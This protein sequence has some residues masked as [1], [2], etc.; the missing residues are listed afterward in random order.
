MKKIKFILF[1]FTALLVVVLVGLKISAATGDYTTYV[2]D[3]DFSKGNGTQLTVN[4]YV[5]GDETKTEVPSEAITFTYVNKDIKYTNI[6][7]L[8]GTSQTVNE[9]SKNGVKLNSSGYLKFSAKASWSAELVIGGSATSS[10]GRPNSVHVVS[11]ANQ[12]IEGVTVSGA[13]T[14]TTTGKI[15]N[16]A[17]NFAKDIV[18]ID[19]GIAGEMNIKRSNGEVFIADMI[20]KVNIPNDSETCKVYFYNG[21]VLQDS[22]T[23][24]IIVGNTISAPDTILQYPEGKI[25]AGWTAN[26]ETNELYD[27]TQPVNGELNLYAIW[28]DYSV[29][30]PNVLDSALLDRWG[31]AYHQITKN[32]KVDFIGTNYSI[33]YN[34]NFITDGEITTV[35]KNTGS[36]NVANESNALIFEA[37]ASGKLIVEVKSGSNKENQNLECITVDNIAAVSTDANIDNTAYKAVEFKITTPGTYY[38]GNTEGTVLY[39]SAKFVEDAELHQYENVGKTSIRYVCAIRNIAAEE[40]A[41]VTVTLKLTLEGVDTVNLNIPIVYTSVLGDNGFAAEEN[42]YYMV[43]TITGLNVDAAYYGKTLTAQVVVTNGL[44][45]VTSIETVYTISNFTA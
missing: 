39:K 23:K 9:A 28:E 1:A 2:Y 10:S 18:K 40:L 8:D 41:N 44:E 37:K 11:N 20:L 29:D 35:L 38:I 45:T 33:T 6:T 12:E 26:P 3:L 25:F 30:N 43:Y 36:M 4:P 7:Y 14:V 16:L 27:F 15:D 13:L 19:N 22:L 42:T 21:D 34:M 17:N 31:Q 5:E 32:D 24:E